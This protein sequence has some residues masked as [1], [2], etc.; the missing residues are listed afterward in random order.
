MKK[1]KSP[2]LLLLLLPPAHQRTSYSFNS[3]HVLLFILTFKF[4]STYRQDDYHSLR[5]YIVLFKIEIESQRRR[6]K[7]R[8]R[9]CYSFLACCILSS[10][11]FFLFLLFRIKARVSFLERENEDRYLFFNADYNTI[12]QFS[13]NQD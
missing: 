9:L 11:S 3:T 7:K 1:K 12:N 6:K 4:N 5:F 13:R 10:R 2:I 8:K